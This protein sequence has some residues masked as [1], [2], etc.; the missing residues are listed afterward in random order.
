MDEPG[1]VSDAGYG[2]GP[3]RV[4]SDRARLQSQEGAQPRRVRRIDGRSG[5]LKGVLVP[6][7]ERPGESIAESRGVGPGFC[8]VGVDSQPGASRIALAE[9]LANVAMGGVFTRSVRLMQRN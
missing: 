1:C 9:D 6:V 7:S 5:G 4:Q 3:S 2:E 8:K